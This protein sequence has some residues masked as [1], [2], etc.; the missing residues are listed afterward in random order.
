MEQGYNSHPSDKQLAANVI[1]Y[2]FLMD[3]YPGELRRI[4]PGK[5]IGIRSNHSVVITAGIKGYI[6]WG[7]SEGGNAIAFLMNNLNMVSYDM[8][9]KELSDWAKDH[10][11]GVDFIYS[12]DIPSDSPTRSGAHA[13]FPETDPNHTD[14]AKQY[15]MSRGISEELVDGLVASK[16]V[17]QTAEG[18]HANVMFKPHHGKFCEVRGCVPGKKYHRSYGEKTGAYWAFQLGQPNTTPKRAYICEGAIDA[19]SLADFRNDLGPA[20]FVAI[21][22]VSNRTAVDTLVKAYPDTEII[23]A[24]DNDEAGHLFAE[25]FKQYKRITPI[26]KDWNEDLQFFREQTKRVEEERAAS[27][28]KKKPNHGQ[29]TR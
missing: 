22:G 27:S 28:K 26:R 11:H 18:A 20:L 1:L 5:R 7:T 17:F 15:L 14:T 10:P 13:P 8:A 3:R 25:H 19:I 4:T 24:T 9:V 16:L 12:T 21:G 23:I 2:D 29:F 6:D